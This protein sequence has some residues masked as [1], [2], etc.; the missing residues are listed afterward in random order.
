MSKKPEQQNLPKKKGISED[1]D[2]YLGISNKDY[3]EL[4]LKNTRI[5][6]RS[7]NQFNPSTPHQN[8]GPSSP[9]QQSDSVKKDKK[10]S[11]KD[12]SASKSKEKASKP[13][14]EDKGI[15]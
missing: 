6:R 11:S 12:I 15:I 10:K 1:S 9:K 5:T 4:V 8:V 3:L 2:A 13:P 7:V 14:R